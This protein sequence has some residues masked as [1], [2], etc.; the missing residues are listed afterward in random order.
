MGCAR[1]LPL[2]ICPGWFP[3]KPELGKAGGEEEWQGSNTGPAVPQR[4]W[5]GWVLGGREWRGQRAEFGGREEV[6]GWAAAS[7][8]G[9][10]VPGAK[11]GGNQHH[12]QQLS[13]FAGPCGCSLQPDGYRAR[14]GSPAGKRCFSSLTGFGDVKED[15][16]KPFEV[17]LSSCL[18]ACENKGVQIPLGDRDALR[19]WVLRRAA[20]SL[21]GEGCASTAMLLARHGESSTTL[22]SLLWHLMS[23]MCPGTEG[24]QQSSAE[25]GREFIKCFVSPRCQS[26]HRSGGCTG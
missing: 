6:G 21:A 26:S 12:M 23:G 1:M 2:R 10:T 24:V 19:R 17:R 13:A 16:Y 22:T 18:P 9:F 11:R 14:H 15:Q 3:K 7:S 4:D 20:A 5:A 8:V 25:P